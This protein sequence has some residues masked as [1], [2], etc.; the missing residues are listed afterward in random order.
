MERNSSSNLPRYEALTHGLSQTP[1]QKH[2]CREA[3][4]DRLDCM[5]EYR[6]PRPE[7][8]Y[9]YVLKVATEFL[10]ILPLLPRPV[11]FDLWSRI[12]HEAECRLKSPLL[13]Q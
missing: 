11:L 13:T 9:G 2:S 3:G 12:E 4:D 5:D 1:L 8:D 6:C 7:T 10:N